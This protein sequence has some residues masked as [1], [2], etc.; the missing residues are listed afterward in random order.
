MIDPSAPRPLWAV[1]TVDPLATPLARW[2]LPRRWATPNRI[3]LLA[4]ACALGASACFATGHLRVGG[5]LFLARYFADC[6]DG[7]LA[8]AR[9]TSS[10]GGALLDIACDVTGVHLTAAALGWWSVRN[11][12]LDSGWALALLA[13]IGTY[14]WAL[15]HRKHLANLAGVGEGGSTHTWPDVPLLG[16]WTRFAARRR[17]MAFP[18][19]LEVEIAVLG[20]VPLLAPAVAPQA[21]AAAAVAYAGFTAVNL[22]R[23]ARVVNRSVSQER[24]SAPDQP[25]RPGGTP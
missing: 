12:H 20:L 9:G 24:P 17:M 14:N 6:L 10:P 15:A 1:L 8:R 18:W 3:T 5:A 4:L 11:G 25:P 23:C 7:M 21:L 16:R 22:W 19:V 13:A 2:L